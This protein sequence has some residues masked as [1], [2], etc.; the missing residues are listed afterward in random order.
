MKTTTLTLVKKTEWIFLFLFNQKAG[1]W[2][3]AHVRI[4]WEIHHV[5]QKTSEKGPAESKMGD[6]LRPPSHLL[7][8][9]MLQRSQDYPSSTSMSVLGKC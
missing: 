7:P 2:C 5:Q 8:G 4:A 1:K 6:P 3:A 9:S